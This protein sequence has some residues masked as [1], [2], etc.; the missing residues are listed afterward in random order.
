[1]D[2]ISAVGQTPSQSIDMAMQT[3][4]NEALLQ[5]CIG[6]CGGA[7][8]L[9]PIIVT[10]S[11]RSDMSVVALTSSLSQGLKRGFVTAELDAFMKIADNPDISSG[12]LARA[13]MTLHGKMALAQQCS[14]ISHKLVEGLQS[15]ILKGG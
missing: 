3:G 14:K 8:V 12:E 9:P 13:T 7:Y 2:P 5:D 4:K 10:A 11:A 1:M 6:D 15:I